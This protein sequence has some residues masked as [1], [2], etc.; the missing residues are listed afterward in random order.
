M[1]K[2]MSMKGSGDLWACLAQSGSECPLPLQDLL[3]DI[4]T[5][6]QMLKRVQ[7]PF[8]F[9][10]FF[11][12]FFPVDIFSRV[13]FFFVWNIAD[14]GVIFSPSAMPSWTTGVICKAFVIGIAPRW[15]RRHLTD[16]VPYLPPPRPPRSALPATHW[17]IFLLGDLSKFSPGLG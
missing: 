8:F 1:Q 9:K 13:I 6:Y 11:L 15:S 17:I 3:R 7:N 14:S 16:S 12:S 10:Y 4:R 2:K 5:R